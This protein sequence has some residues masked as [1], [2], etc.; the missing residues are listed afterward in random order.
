MNIEWFEDHIY[1]GFQ[2]YDDKSKSM[3]TSYIPQTQKIFRMR[4]VVFA[5]GTE[6]SEG[7]LTLPSGNT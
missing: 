5:A 7:C 4:S 2:T 3:M 6:Y 1:E